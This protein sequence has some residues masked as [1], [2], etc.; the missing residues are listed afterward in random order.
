[1]MDGNSGIRL[2]P[3][4]ITDDVHDLNEKL[5]RTVAFSSEVQ[6]DFFDEVFVPNYKSV[7]PSVFRSFHTY[8][9]LTAHILAFEP[10]H[11]V[12]DLKE[13]GFK[14]IVFHLS[15]TDFANEIIDKIHRLGMEAGIG[16]DPETDTSS[17]NPFAGRVNEYLFLAVDPKHPGIF[18][19][20]VLKKVRRWRSDYPKARIS[21]DGA[22]SLENIIDVINAGANVAY[23]GNAIYGYGEPRDNYQAFLDKIE[24]QKAS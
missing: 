17:L 8:A 16:I 2:I 22:V 23:V 13:A 3:A 10:E 11:M 21:V 9:E 1:M 6:I 12:D 4:I 19:P 5:T 24:A 7:S 18:K 20:G 14:K 15:T